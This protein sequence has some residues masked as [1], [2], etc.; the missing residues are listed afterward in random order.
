MPVITAKKAKV[1]SVSRFA[2]ATRAPEKAKT[3]T[4]AQSR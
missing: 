2:A 4:P 3:A 1:T